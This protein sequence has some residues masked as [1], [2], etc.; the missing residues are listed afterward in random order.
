MNELD[1]LSGLRAEIPLADSRTAENAVLTA[2]RAET[3]AG[4][5]LLLGDAAPEPRPGGHGARKHHP[6]RRMRPMM[7]IGL[8]AVTFAATA[9]GVVVSHGGTQNYAGAWHYEIA[10]SGRPTAPWRV[11]S[12][13]YGRARTAAQ[14]IGY[15]T[16]IAAVTRAPKPHDW[17]AIQFDERG[18]TG[19]NAGYNP[20]TGPKDHVLGPLADQPTTGVT[21]E[22]ADLCA[23]AGF[24][25]LP[26][27]LPPGTTF[28]GHLLVQQSGCGGDMTIGGWNPSY[29]Y[30]NTLPTDPA[31]LENI[32]ATQIYP[33]DSPQDPRDDRVFEAI[34]Y[35]FE[36]ELQG[37][38]VPPRLAATLYQVLQRIPGVSFE[39]GAT[40]LAGRT[41]LG[42]TKVVWGYLQETIII[43]PVTYAYMGVKSVAAT[44]HTSTGLD[45]TFRTLKGQVIFWDALLA[46]AIVKKPG[47]MP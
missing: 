14:L 25:S 19:S 26:D 8:A 37:L 43:D 3:N 13:S 35:L 4:L 21:W 17:I 42:F 5:R 23:Y 36:G 20:G 29:R 9:I 1:L 41:G 34:K 10:W 11:P 33:A 32:I 16:R 15:T 7:A 30:L 22:R 12:V 47:Q 39:T 27:Y 24:T 28:H 6:R 2:I 38:V 45:G 40:D 31:A 18:P 44:D 46:T